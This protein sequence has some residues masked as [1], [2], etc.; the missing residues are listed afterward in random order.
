MDTKWKKYSYSITAKI[1]AFLLVV[2]C[3]TGLLTLFITGIGFHNF[4]YN[5]LT[6]ES[7]YRSRDF[8]N[9]SN[10]VLQNITAIIGEYK[11]EENILSGGS[12][13]ADEL[14]NKEENLYREFKET[15]KNYNPNMSEAENDQVFR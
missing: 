4:D 2:G 7:Y 1:I 9:V 11:S 13:T 15:S 10:E 3:Y 14:K 6:E 5:A 8:T 12:I